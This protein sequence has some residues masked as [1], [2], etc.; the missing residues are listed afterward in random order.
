[1]PRN[2]AYVA[3]GRGLVIAVS[4]MWPAIFSAPAS[5]VSGTSDGCYCACAPDFLQPQSKCEDP[6]FCENW[7]RDYRNDVLP[8]DSAPSVS[9]SQRVMETSA[10]AGYMDPQAAGMA[11]MLDTMNMLF[12]SGSNDAN[13]ARAEAALKAQQ[14]AERRRREAEAEARNDAMRAN[15]LRNL[16]TDRPMGRFDG[17]SRVVGGLKLKTTDNDND[18]FPGLR[19]DRGLIAGLKT[20][21]EEHSKK[22][23]DKAGVLKL[24]SKPT[25]FQKLADRYQDAQRQ[26]A[27][28]RR[29]LEEIRK[30]LQKKDEE[31]KKK[32]KEL[33]ERKRG[34]PAPA[35]MPKLK[36]DAPAPAPKPDG[37]PAPG[38]KPEDD[39]D[40]EAERLLREA[41]ADEADLKRKETGLDRQLRELEAQEKEANDALQSYLKSQ[42]GGASKP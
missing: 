7:C 21:E 12:K 9:W 22:E 16:K 31:L 8:K 28:V 40:A 38:E 26:T 34:G 35:P 14:E 36:T 39:A 19:R 15:L 42:A 11:V 33:E 13:R 6:D 17:N 25:Q 20:D 30:E 10:R 4:L 18:T 37:A 1:M 3:L 23:S 29:R 27:V 32:R 5:A 2:G 41:E 24:A